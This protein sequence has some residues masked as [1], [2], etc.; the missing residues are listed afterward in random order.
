MRYR[1]FRTDWTWYM[2]PL[3]LKDEFLKWESYQRAI[4]PEAGNWQGTDFS[5]YEAHPTDFTFTDPAEDDK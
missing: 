3:S 1:F 4:A 5:L 2:I